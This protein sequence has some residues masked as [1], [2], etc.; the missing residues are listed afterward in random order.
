MPEFENRTRR[1]LSAAL[2]ELLREEPLDQLR[3][4]ELTERCGLRRQ[5]FYYHFKD[6]YDLL[7][8]AVRQERALL[9]D[10]LAE[11]LTWRQALLALLDRAGEERAFYR[12]VLDQYG[13]EGLGEMI[14]LEEALEAVQIYYR[15]RCGRPP[16]RNGEERDRRRSRAMLLSLLEG[17]VRNEGAL[18]PE[19]LADALER[20]A[21]R[22][23][24]GAV[25]QT[26]RERGE[27]CWTP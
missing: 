11:C 22:G 4:R 20:V 16:D 23:A 27:W 10:R 6:V 18:P 17:W 21:E 24:E 2:R 1:E 3:V 7:A 14:P 25:W 12:A 26:L 5:S 15:D 8:W 9:A 19:E 13:Q